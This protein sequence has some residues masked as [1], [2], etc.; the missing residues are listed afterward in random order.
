MSIIKHFTIRVT[1]TGSCRLRLPDFKPRTP[2]HCIDHTYFFIS[3]HIFLSPINNIEGGYR[4]S[5]HS[6][7]HL[8]VC[9][10]LWKKSP[11]TATIFHW[12]LP[13]IYSMLIPLKICN[14]F[15]LQVLIHTVSV[16]VCSLHESMKALSDCVSQAEAISARIDEEME[17]LNA[18][19]TEENSG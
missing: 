14:H 1:P 13:N 9:P 6:S 19:E 10:S 18:M 3:H 7:I 12:S 11:L 5:Q 8:P 17:K 16:Y 15:S 2:V 4:N